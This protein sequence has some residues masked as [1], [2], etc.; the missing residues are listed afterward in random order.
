PRRSK[1]MLGESHTN[2]C[3]IHRCIAQPTMAREYKSITTVGYSHPSSV[4]ISVIE[5]VTHGLNAMS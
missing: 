2:W 4:Q 3:V 1:A 5:L